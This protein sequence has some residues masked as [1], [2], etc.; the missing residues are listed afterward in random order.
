MS[1]GGVRVTLV[2]ESCQG[3]GRDTRLASG[4]VAQPR[5][6][7]DVGRRHDVARRPGASDQDQETL[8][9][10]MTLGRRTPHWR[11]SSVVWASSTSVVS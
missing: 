2:F 9:W 10:T 4:A 5:A 11:R 7:V 6:E 3:T 8:V 1:S